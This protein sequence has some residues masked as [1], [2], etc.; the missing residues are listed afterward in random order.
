M[1]IFRYENN[2]IVWD[3]KPGDRYLVIGY[4]YNSNKKFRKESESTVILG[5]NLWRG[6]KYLIR[7]GK[8]HLIQKVTN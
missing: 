7:D 2:H 6:R 5:I 3:Y 1:K 8:R 4:Y